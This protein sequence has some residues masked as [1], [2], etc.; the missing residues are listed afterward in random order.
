MA[1][2]PQK[3]QKAPGGKDKNAQ[4]KLIAASAVL[5]IAIVWIAYY[6]GVFAGDPNKPKELSADQ[7][8]KAEEEVKTLQEEHKK[9]TSK[10]PPIKGRPPSTGGS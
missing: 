1:K 2:A 3:A 7:L 8:Q 9:E 4:I 10:G 6:M 5:V